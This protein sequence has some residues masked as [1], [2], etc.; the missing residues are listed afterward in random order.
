MKLLLSRETLQLVSGCIRKGVLA[1]RR[2]EEKKT[3]RGAYAEKSGKRNA[4][5][6]QR[7]VLAQERETV[8][9]GKCD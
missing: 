7:G 9:K 6:K 8:I 3:F 2:L 1:K 5:Q 4:C